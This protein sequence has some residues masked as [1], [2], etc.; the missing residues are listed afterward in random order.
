MTTEIST[1]NAEELKSRVRELG[2]F[3]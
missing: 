3:L 1:A 2:R